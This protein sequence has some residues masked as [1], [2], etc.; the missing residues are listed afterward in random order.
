[1]AEVRHLPRQ[2]RDKRLDAPNFAWLSRRDE[3]AWRAGRY[4]ALGVILTRCVSASA[5]G[6]RLLFSA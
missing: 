5:A 4:S 2:G 6:M 1:M 3:T